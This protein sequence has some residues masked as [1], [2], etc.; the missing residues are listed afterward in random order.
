MRSLLVAL[1]LLSAAAIPAGAAEKVVLLADP[2]CPH[3]CAPGGRPGYMIE[4]A[5]KAFAARG[6]EVEYRTVAWARAMAEVRQGRAD[7]AVG[8]LRDEAADLVVHDEAL[9]WQANVFAVRADDGWAYAG[10]DSLAGRK[11]GSIL[12]YSYSPEVDAWLAAHPGQVQAA[13]GENALDRNISKLLSGRVD[14][15][16]EDSAVLTW[17]LRA[18]PDRDKI[19][20]A[21]KTAGGALFIAFSPADGRGARL[22]SILDQGIR[23]LR[24]SGALRSILDGYGFSDWKP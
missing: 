6:I 10:L 17:A 11:V 24:A 1:L 5:T 16:V 23:E 19:R 20:L 8:A 15:V 12:D 3:T 13:G 4:I 7:G 22:A 2:W 21:G 9:G 18:R 14:V